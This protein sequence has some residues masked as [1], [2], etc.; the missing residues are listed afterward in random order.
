MKKKTL[1]LIG[2][3]LISLLAILYLAYDFKVTAYSIADA[4]FVVG[5][6]CLFPGLIVA[7]RASEL[8]LG[9]DYASK[10]LFKRRGEQGFKSIAD[11]KAYKEQKNVGR[12]GRQERFR[13]LA[14]GLAYILGSLMINILW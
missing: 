4:M 9:M 11:Y 1:V 8:F 7:T 13:L 2:V 12:D 14:M 10:Q 6:C 5:I 3:S